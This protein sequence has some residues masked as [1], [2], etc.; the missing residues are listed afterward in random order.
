MTTTRRTA[1][2]TTLVSA[3]LTV[4]LAGGCD[5]AASEPSGDNGART[6]GS[7]VAAF[8]VTSYTLDSSSGTHRFELFADSSRIG[9]VAY[10]PGGKVGSAVSVELNGRTLSMTATDS[11]ATVEVD[12]RR[13]DAVFDSVTHRWNG[14]SGAVA[15]NADLL[16]LAAALIADAGLERPSGAPPATG[17]EL[18][19]RGEAAAP[20]VAC[21]GPWVTSAVYWASTRSYACSLAWQDASNKCSNAYCWGCCSFSPCNSWCWFGDFSCV[22]SASG[23]QCGP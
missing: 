3:L 5:R 9:K 12:G 16:Q 22:A 10:V 6:A 8:G 2:S 15:A 1:R 19:S 20:A 13:S 23:E 17:A 21:Y 4:A 14:D 11:G 18:Q 7:A